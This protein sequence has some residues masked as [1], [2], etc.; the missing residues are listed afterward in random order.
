[1]I[2]REMLDEIKEVWADYLGAPVVN[3]FLDFV[4]PP[5]PNDDAHFEQFKAKRLAHKIRYVARVFPGWHRTLGLRVQWYG[6]FPKRSEISDDDEGVCP[7]CGGRFVV[8]RSYDE[9]T[10]RL[11]G[12]AEKF[13]AMMAECAARGGK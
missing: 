9:H 5:M 2:D 7:E 1:M 13:L 3:V 4:L 11:Y 10:L 6:H 8:V 12:G